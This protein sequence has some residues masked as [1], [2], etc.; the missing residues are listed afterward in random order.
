MTQV[1]TMHSKLMTSTSPT[2]WLKCHITIIDAST[3]LTHAKYRINKRN[4]SH[5]TH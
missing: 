5:P 2:H 3:G 1:Q 4:R